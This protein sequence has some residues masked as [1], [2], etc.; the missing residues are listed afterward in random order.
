[1]T[2]TEGRITELLDRIER[3]EAEQRTLREQLTTAQVEQWQG[4]IEDIELQTH[5]ASMEANDRITALRDELRHQWHDVTAQLSH[6][7]HTATDVVESVRD[8]IEG[9]IRN[10]REALLESR[11]K[12][13]TKG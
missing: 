9:A 1:M 4:R 5:L 7:T 6:S 11:Q 13:G 2:D 10:V 3:L 12:A 8:G